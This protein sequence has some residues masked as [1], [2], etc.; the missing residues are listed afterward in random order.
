[1]SELLTQKQILLKRAGDSFTD[2]YAIL[3]IHCNDTD[4]VRITKNQLSL[5]FEMVFKTL[6]N[7]SRELNKFDNISELNNLGHN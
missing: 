7:D 2:I 5:A 4:L 6:Q 1:M 3:T